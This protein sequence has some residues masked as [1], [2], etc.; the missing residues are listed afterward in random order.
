MATKEEDAVTELF[1]TSTHT[2]VLFFSTLGKVYRMKVWRLPEGGADDAR[3][4]DDQPAAAGRGRDDLD[5]AAAARGRGG[6]GQAPRHVRDRQGLACGATRWTR[7][8]TCRTAGK[9]AMKFEGDDEDDRLIGVALARRRRRRAARDAR[10]A[11][12]SAS[13]ATEVREFQSRNSTGVRGMRAEQGRRGHLAVDPPQGRRQG[14]GRARGLS[15]LRAVEERER[16][17]VRKPRDVRRC[18]FADL[19]RAR[20]VHPDRLR[21]RLWQ[22]VVGLRISPHRPRRPGH[23]QHRQHR[24]QRPRRRELPGAPR[25]IS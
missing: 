14:P 10:R 2:P 8:P 1:V 18:A 23:H 13:P 16:E 22:A 20:A 25:A 4:A 15:P 17:G 19:R 7:S 3:A 9:I 11:R 21:Q 12:R 5:R 24:A 6:M